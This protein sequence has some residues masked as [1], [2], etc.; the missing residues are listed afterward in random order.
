MAGRGMSADKLVSA[1][2]RSEN[3][4]VT[5]QPIITVVGTAFWDVG[6][7]SQYQSLHTC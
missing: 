1:S 4:N 3:F 5:G 7:L 2:L 6:Q